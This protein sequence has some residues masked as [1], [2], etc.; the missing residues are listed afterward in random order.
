MECSVT[1]KWLSTDDFVLAC[2]YKHRCHTMHPCTATHALHAPTILPL[3]LSRRCRPA[4]EEWPTMFTACFGSHSV[5]VKFAVIGGPTT[6]GPG[7]WPACCGMIVSADTAAAQQCS[8]LECHHKLA[9]HRC[10]PGTTWLDTRCEPVA[11]K[12]SLSSELLT[13]GIRCVA[14]GA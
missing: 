2:Y 7:A 10:T 8:S 9:W 6:P 11:C 5:K 12:L 14:Q 4:S 1:H 3:W 13:G